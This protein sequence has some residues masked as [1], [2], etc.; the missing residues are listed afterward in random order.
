MRRCAWIALLAVALGLVGCQSKKSV[1]RPMRDKYYRTAVSLSPGTTEIFAAEVTNVP[2]VGRTAADNWPPR[3]SAIPI[4]ASVKPNYERLSTLKPELVVYDAALFSPDDV[5]KIKSTTGATL[6]AIKANTLGD[7]TK[8]LYE[9]GTLTGSEVAMNN[10]VTKILAEVGN[11]KVEPFNPV[12]KVAVIL[13]G[14]GGRDYIAGTGSFVASAVEAAGGTPVGPNDTKFVAV[15]PESLVGMNPDVI[16]VSGTK[17][18][19]SGA[20]ALL[21]NPRYQTL[22]A[23]KNGR[24]RAIDED[25][26]VRRGGRVDILLKALHQSM[27]PSAGGG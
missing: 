12:P 15:S 16:I 11:A 19:M 21:K 14:E 13:P 18:D 6:F 20:V 8:E 2:L 17:A 23:I 10:Y 22:S 25:V 1:Q 24:V 27:K 26:L 7:F 3:V 5:E 4:V 9:L